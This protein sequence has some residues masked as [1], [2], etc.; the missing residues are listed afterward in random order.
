MAGSARFVTLCVAFARCHKHSLAQ[1]MGTGHGGDVTATPRQGFRV[2]VDRERDHSLDGLEMAKEK[3]LMWGSKVISLSFAVTETKPC[4]AHLLRWLWQ[5]S[6]LHADTLT[7]QFRPEAP[8][9]R[10]ACQPC[11][12]AAAPRRSVGKCRCITLV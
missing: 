2:L 6:V 5:G 8:C 12:S 1:L 11:I 4:R 7:S 3:R 10:R 9:A